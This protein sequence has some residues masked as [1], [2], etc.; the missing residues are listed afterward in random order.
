M[1]KKGNRYTFNDWM[2]GA[3]GPVTKGTLPPNYQSE[4]TY[5]VNYIRERGWRKDGKQWIS[6]RSGNGVATVSIA[7]RAQTYEDEVL[8]HD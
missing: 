2:S 3:N 4:Y 6:P 1:G 8:N 7:Y 5:M